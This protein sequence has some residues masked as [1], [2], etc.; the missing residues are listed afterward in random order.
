MLAVE[1]GGPGP[2]PQWEAAVRSSCEQPKVSRFLERLRTK[3]NLTKEIS[4]QAD[5]ESI[6]KPL[7]TP[8]PVTR[9]TQAVDAGPVAEG[10]SE[11]LLKFYKV[12]SRRQ[13]PL[14]VDSRTSVME[15]YSRK[16]RQ[17][18]KSASSHRE[19]SADGGQRH[20]MDSRANKSLQVIKPPTVKPQ[21]NIIYSPL[22]KPLIPPQ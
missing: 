15:P 3:R 4:C 19:A 18:L 2:E 20:P 7:V 6:A 11:A 5:E 9:Q 16:W 17:R 14:L 1:Q 8:R 12:R 13:Q 22:K 10:I 21:N